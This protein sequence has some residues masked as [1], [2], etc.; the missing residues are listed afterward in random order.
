MVEYMAHDKWM[1]E[2]YEP[3]ETTA[4]D[5]A[6]PARFVRLM[7][8]PATIPDRYW[9]RDHPWSGVTMRFITNSWTNSAQFAPRP[10]VD[11]ERAF[12]H[13][14]TLCG[15]YGPRHEHKEAAVALLAER[16]FVGIA[17]GG[18]LLF[19]EDWEGREQVSRQRAP[20]RQESASAEG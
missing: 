17:D 10:G 1:Q 16:W 18:R 15:S 13:L 6:F 3:Q 12:W 5:R 11:G 8:D 4:A 14:Y 20:G 7:P 9:R 19:G 2:P